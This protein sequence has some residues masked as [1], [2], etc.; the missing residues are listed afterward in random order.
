MLAE[1]AT[2]VEILDEMKSLCNLIPTRGGEAAVDCAALPGMPTVEFVL[3]GGLY[4]LLY[5]F[6]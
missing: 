5:V 1:N 3:G 4:E 6:G 2:R